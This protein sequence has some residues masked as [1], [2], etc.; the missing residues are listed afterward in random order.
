[1]Q[2]GA[3]SVAQGAVRP[4]ARAARASRAVP[5]P[6]PPATPSQRV[7]VAAAAAATVMASTAGAVP[8]CSCSSGLASTSQASAC[9]TAGGIAAAAA[10][11]AARPHRRRLLFES[12]EQP[13]ASAS[14]PGQPPQGQ[15]RRLDAAAQQQLARPR[16]RVVAAGGPAGGM[17]AAGGHGGR[18]EPVNTA[19]RRVLLGVAVAYVSLVVIIPFINVFIQAFHNGVGPFLEHVLDPDFAHATKM[20]LALAAVSVPLNCVF[21][22]VAAILITRNEFPGKVLLLSLLDMPFSISPVVTGLML[23]LLY[24]RSGLFASFL[25][26]HGFNVVFA[27]P[28]AGPFFWAGGGGAAWAVHGCCFGGGVFFGRCFFWGGGCIERAR[29]K[30]TRDTHTAHTLNKH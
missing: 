25:A 17:G 2:L 18:G 10:A 4:V 14:A 28:G 27:F 11:A 20:T 9:A 19:A 29:A 23:T 16:G 3:P 1:M 21:G 5:L 13:L 26:E 12:Q 30:N 22:T 7:A 15:Q 6:P 24:G 8:A